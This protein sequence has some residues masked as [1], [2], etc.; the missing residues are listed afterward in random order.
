MALNDQRTT[1][2]IHRVVPAGEITV[3]PQPIKTCWCAAR[4]RL[5]TPSKP[6][7]AQINDFERML[8]D[9]Q[10]WC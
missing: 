10:W 6:P 1:R 3:L 8:S 9:R 5:I 2:R 7:S 4:Q